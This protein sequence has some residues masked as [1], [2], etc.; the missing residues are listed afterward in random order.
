MMMYGCDICAINETGLNGDEYVEASNLYR[1]IGTGR[2]V[3]LDGLV[4][5]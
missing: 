1:W 5:S 4:L 3:N 2:K